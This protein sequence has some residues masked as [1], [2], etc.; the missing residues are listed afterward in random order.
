VIFADSAKR[1]AGLAAGRLGWAPETF[2]AASPQDVA[3]ALGLG[4]DSGDAGA[5]RTLLDALIERFPDDKE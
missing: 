3:N 2:W 4:G 5:D 1:L